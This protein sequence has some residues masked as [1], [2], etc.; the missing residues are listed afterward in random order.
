[1][2]LFKLGYGSR[3]MAMKIQLK[4]TLSR[5]LRSV[6]ERVR[7]PVN[8]RE[9]VDARTGLCRSRESLGIRVIGGTCSGHIDFSNPF[10]RSGSA[11]PVKCWV[12]RDR[13][14]SL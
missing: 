14:R 8:F 7:G 11:L 5:S 1:M 6:P 13:S 12:S 9:G 3:E 2:I 10:E 4:Q